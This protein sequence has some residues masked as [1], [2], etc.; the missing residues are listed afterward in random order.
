[1]DPLMNLVRLLLINPTNHYIC[2]LALLFVFFHKNNFLIARMH[3]HLI[4]KLE[5]CKMRS[6]Y[7]KHSN[8]FYKSVNK[9]IQT[10]PSSKAFLHILIKCH[11]IS[12]HP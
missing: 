11:N 5:V 6:L 7:G 9:A 12:W 2:H 3:L 1:M 8:V 4:H 10:L